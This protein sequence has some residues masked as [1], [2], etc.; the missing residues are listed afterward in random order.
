MTSCVVDPR[1]LEELKSSIIASLQIYS[2]PSFNI[3]GFDGKLFENQSY[4]LLMVL[5]AK[6]SNWILSGFRL[7]ILDWLFLHPVGYIMSH[8]TFIH[9]FLFFFYFYSFFISIRLSMTPVIWWCANSISVKTSTNIPNTTRFRT[10]S[11]RSSDWYLTNSVIASSNLINIYI[12]T[13]EP[14]VW[15]LILLEV[16]N[17]YLWNLWWMK[18][19]YISKSGENIFYIVSNNQKYHF[20]LSMVCHP[21]L[22][23]WIGNICDRRFIRWAS[24]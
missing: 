3:R 14:W 5:E 10:Q 20:F 23:K 12:I 24:S 6:I 15:D 9:S 4:Q 18:L 19:P 2:V 1:V 8:R 16:L 17:Q 11:A 22:S 13:A 7:C 21:I